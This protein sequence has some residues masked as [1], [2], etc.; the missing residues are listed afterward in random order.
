MD[1]PREGGQR[2][3]TFAW[4]V[5]GFQTH[6]SVAR[7]ET[8]SAKARSLRTLKLF[9]FPAKLISF[10]MSVFSLSRHPV[11]ERHQ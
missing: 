7:R 9:R 10:L 6:G 11:A 4:L 1:A 3:G 2:A 5:S 8:Q